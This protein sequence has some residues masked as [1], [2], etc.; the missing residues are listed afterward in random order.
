MQLGTDTMDSQRGGCRRARRARA[1]FEID[2]PSRM[3][4]CGDLAGGRARRHPTLGQYSQTRPCP[5][6]KEDQSEQETEFL[7]A[8]LGLGGTLPDYA[9]D[10]QEFRS[11]HVLA[12]VVDESHL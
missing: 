11:P 3:L 7:Q 5:V 8:G 6:R 12:A 9:L 4:T 1:G 10:A 2:H